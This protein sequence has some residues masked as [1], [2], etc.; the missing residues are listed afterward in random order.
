MAD[1]L[2]KAVSIFCVVL[3][4]ILAVGLVLAIAFGMQSVERDPFGGRPRW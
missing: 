3:G 4:A 2:V 1:L